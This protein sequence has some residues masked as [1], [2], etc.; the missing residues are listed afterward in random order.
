MI[1]LQKIFIGHIK[2]ERLCYPPP[3]FLKKFRGN[4]IFIIRILFGLIFLI[5]G[6][7]KILDLN[8]FVNDIKN[9]AIV[10]DIFAPALSYFIPVTELLLGTLIIFNIKAKRAIQIILY[11]LTLFLA[12]VTTKLIEGGG[13]SCGCFG[14]IFQDNI[15]I[16]TLLRNILLI[17]FGIVISLF[18]EDSANKNTS[19]SNYLFITIKKL[20]FSLIISFLIIQSFLFAV[21]NVE[22]K[23][24]IYTLSTNQIL[25]IGEKVKALNLTNV[26]GKTINYNYNKTL[27]FIMKYGCGICMENQ[28][29]WK[30]INTEIKDQSINILAICIDSLDIV[31]KLKKDYRISYPVYSNP[32]IDFQR[33][34]K[35]VLVPQTILVD[36]NGIVLNTW[37][38]LLKKND[39]KE[40][41][42]ECKI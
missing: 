15:T 18:I 17:I 11:L 34:F 32:S 10:P 28:N 35:I 9:L 23:N 37:R 19:K 6:L 33:N 5:S 4:I 29:N 20:G 3:L 21:E 2:Y 25:S 41:I 1:N 8:K 31:K 26:E 36:S 12:V 24:R 30:Y 27:L 40:I 16:F 42:H 14:S 13:G 7:S 22:L 39:I 38:G